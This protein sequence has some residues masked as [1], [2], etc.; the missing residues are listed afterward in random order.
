MRARV[1]VRLR[2]GAGRRIGAAFQPRRLEASAGTH[3]RASRP[4]RCLGPARRSA[5]CG[6]RGAARI[7]KRARAQG[8]RRQGSPLNTLKHAT[9]IGGDHMYA[10]IRSLGS[11]GSAGSADAAGAAPAA[12][13]AAGAVRGDSVSCS[14]AIEDASKIWS[15]PPRTAPSRSANSLS[16]EGCTD[17]SR[18]HE[19]PLAHGSACNSTVRAPGV[20]FALHGALSGGP[21]HPHVRV[22]GRGLLRRPGF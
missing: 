22:Y 14:L 8:R 20:S 16:R 21:W 2:R 18:L 5:S 19:K 12:A 13:G 6:M 1:W 11:A 4:R 7:L 15:R 10:L 9:S 3:G 17:A